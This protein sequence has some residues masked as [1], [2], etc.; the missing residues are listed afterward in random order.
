ML[1]KIVNGIV[2]MVKRRAGGVLRELEDSDSEIL[3]LSG[4]NELALIVNGVLS[5]FLVVAMS[6]QQA[7]AV[8]MVVP[9][10]AGVQGASQVSKVTSLS[11]DQLNEWLKKFSYRI[12][13]WSPADQKI[14]IKVNNPA[15]LSRK[16]WRKVVSE[17]FA[18]KMFVTES[19]ETI[20]YLLPPGISSN[21]VQ[22][23]SHY[24][25]PTA[26]PFA[27]FD[28]AGLVSVKTLDELP[29]IKLL[30]QLSAAE[31]KSGIAYERFVNPPNAVSA[32][33]FKVEYSPQLQA[34]APIPDKS[35]QQ[36]ELTGFPSAG[37]VLEFIQSQTDK[38]WLQMRSPSGSLY[39][40]TNESNSP[41]FTIQQNRVGQE[42]IAMRAVMPNGTPFSYT[43]IKTGN[44]FT[45]TTN[46]I[47]N[48][49]PITLLD[50]ASLGV[51]P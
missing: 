14:I 6:S 31:K 36:Q 42:T 39:L 20:I 47:S 32:Y 13:C 34:M 48:K 16:Q 25:A 51:T 10:I 2:G 49:G 22:A 40:T 35:T 11:L 5:I 17:S 19:N 23:V 18:N 9:P 41:Q 24:M 27:G 7:K 8:G 4:R 28:S 1:Q 33:A 45:S 44:S 3:N 30:K 46:L 15:S 29:E 26:D 12:I 21:R 37:G 38:Q 50:F 43:I